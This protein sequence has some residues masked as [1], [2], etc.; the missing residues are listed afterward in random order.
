MHTHL[1]AHDTND[2]EDQKSCFQSLNKND[3]ILVWCKGLAK[4]AEINNLI[5]RTA[6]IY[7]CTHTHMATKKTLNEL[8]M[9]KRRYTTQMARTPK[10]RSKQQQHLSNLGSHNIVLYTTTPIS[11]SSA[12][13]WET[14]QDKRN[15]QAQ[16]GTYQTMTHT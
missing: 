2:K 1:L 3:Q 11:C 8:K 4:V 10:K 13:L 15:T 12:T 5:L 16:L 9:R 14:E 6:F 7:S